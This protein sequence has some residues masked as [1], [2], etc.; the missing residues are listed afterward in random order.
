MI[1]KVSFFTSRP[2]ILS[3][4]CHKINEF[5]FPKHISILRH[6]SARSLYNMK[7]NTHDRF[8]ILT[9][10]FTN[11]IAGL[12]FLLSIVTA[13]TVHEFAH[14]KSADM[15]GDPTPA[16]LGRV[17]LDPRAHLDLMGSI[18]FLL[19]G[20]GWGKPVPF[21]PYNLD[22]PKRDAAIIALAG[23]GSNFIMAGI[24]SGILY[25]F[26]LIEPNAW[27]LIGQGFLQTFIWINLVLGI[28]NLLPFAPLDG[29]KIVG[30]ILSDDQAAQW[31]GL[32]RYG[33]IF[34]LFFIFP[35]AGGQSMLQ[36]FLTPIIQT[37]VGILI[38]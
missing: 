14:A 29:F 19:I 17:T 7:N 31:Y 4:R 3:N 21:D 27:I 5:T 22:N 10:V 33:I 24:S 1:P 30:G 8:M 35:F 26:T 23:P 38:P 37:L 6:K 9:E 15:L 20:F 25:M 32:E 18:L 16:T 28:F 2:Y 34:L 11:P 13:V 36:L 12:F